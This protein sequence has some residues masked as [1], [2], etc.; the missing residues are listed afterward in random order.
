MQQ[1]LP[2]WNKFSKLD[3]LP[4][5]IIEIIEAKVWDNMAD[6][7]RIINSMKCFDETITELNWI[8]FM[9]QEGII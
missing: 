1:I 4:D 7:T 6:E 2:N 8:V 5:E 3:E 9:V